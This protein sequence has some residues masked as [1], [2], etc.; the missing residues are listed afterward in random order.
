MTSQVRS[1]LGVTSSHLHVHHTA[2]PR[3]FRALPLSFVTLLE[4]RGSVS[5]GIAKASSYTLTRHTSRLLCGSARCAPPPSER[6]PPRYQED[7]LPSKIHRYCGPSSGKTFPL[8]LHCTSKTTPFTE[9]WRVWIIP[10][11]NPP[12][13]WCYGW[14]TIPSPLGQT[15]SGTCCIISPV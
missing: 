14:W 4:P 2:A 12:C 5:G 13:V 15:T 11:P 1:K 6:E 10:L 7:L 8:G 3:Y 9:F